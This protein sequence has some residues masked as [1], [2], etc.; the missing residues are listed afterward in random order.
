MLE[1]TQEVEVGVEVPSEFK[2]EV[3]NMKEKFV[4]LINLHHIILIIN[5]KNKKMIKLHQRI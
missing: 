5:R 4:H 1:D 3:G 2:E